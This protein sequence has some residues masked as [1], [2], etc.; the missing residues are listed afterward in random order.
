M[1]STGR[2]V[3]L[4]A[5]EIAALPEVPLGNLEGV[6]H[7]VLWRNDT[8]MAGVLTV[9]GGHRLGAHRHHA[10]HHHLWMLEG[11]A[12]ILGVEIAAGGYVHVPVGIEHDIDATRTE[13]CTVFYLYLRE[14]T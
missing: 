5:A 3:V 4:T 12:T 2:A 9:R 11:R 1:T 6:S 7:R 8:S 14:G 13:G 10:N